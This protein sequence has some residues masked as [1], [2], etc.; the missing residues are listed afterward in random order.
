[1]HD[2]HPHPLLAQVPLTISPFLSLPTSVPLP[3]SYKT[4]PSTLPA[5][6]LQPQS[7]PNNPQQQQPQQQQP[8]AYV[9]SASGTS[10]TPDAILTSCLALQQHL[11]KL[12]TDARK[13]LKEWEDRRAAEDLAEKRRLAPGW[14]DSGVHIIKPE[15]EEKPQRNAGEAEVANLMDDDPQKRQQEKAGEELDRVFGGLQV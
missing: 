5:S 15:A 12:E 2:E 14:L 3:Y 13:T 6:I 1:M 7:D 11:Q 9:Q 8:P 4:L 10:A